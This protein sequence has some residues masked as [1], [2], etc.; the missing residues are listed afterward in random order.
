MYAILWSSDR[1]MDRVYQ[2][3]LPIRFV[4][5]YQRWKENGSQVFWQQ[6]EQNVILTERTCSTIETIETQVP[7]I[8]SFRLPAVTTTQNLWSSRHISILHNYD[9]KKEKA[10][11]ITLQL[12][13][14]AWKKGT[15][16]RLVCGRSSK[17]AK[18]LLLAE[19]DLTWIKV[20]EIATAID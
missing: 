7:C 5:Q 18:R 10:W 16:D 3:I 6:L 9:Q 1:G 13:K 20:L 15:K 2:K 17:N 4:E 19:A 14:N 12:G 8:S 11:Q